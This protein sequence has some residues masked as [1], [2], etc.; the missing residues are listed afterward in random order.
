MP[1][2]PHAHKCLK[3]EAATE[4][5]HDIANAPQVRHLVLEQATRKREQ[6]S[7]D[8]RAQNSACHTNECNA[9][10]AQGLH[11]PCIKPPEQPTLAGE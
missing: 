1:G 5:E 8:C 9:Q 10:C 11:V 7:H 2:S 6:A 4:L 3:L